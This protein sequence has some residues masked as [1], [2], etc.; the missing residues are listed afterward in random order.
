MQSGFSEE[1]MNGDDMGLEGMGAALGD[2][3][4]GL[5]G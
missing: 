4:K 5:A 1:D 3:I 2:L